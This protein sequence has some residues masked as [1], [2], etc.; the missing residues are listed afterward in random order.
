MTTP[1]CPRCGNTSF[2]IGEMKIEKANYPHNAIVCRKCG[3]IVGIEEH[4]SVLYILRK[5]AE[6]LDVES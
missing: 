3:C 5:I 1:S 2:E 6:K 4:L